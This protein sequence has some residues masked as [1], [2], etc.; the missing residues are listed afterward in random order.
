M[1]R[2][3]A[4]SSCDLQRTSLERTFSHVSNNVYWLGTGR[5]IR[6]DRTVTDLSCHP[7]GMWETDKKWAVAGTVPAKGWILLR[8]S[9]Q[10][11]IDGKTLPF[12]NYAIADRDSHALTS[13]IFLADSFGDANTI[14]VPGASAFCASVTHPGRSDWTLG[15]WNLPDANAI[16]IATDL[17]NHIVTRASASSPVVV[18]ERW[19]Y[20]WLNLLKITPEKLEGSLVNIRSGRRLASLKPHMQHGNYASQSSIRNWYFQ[21]ALSPGGD[22]LA[23]GGDGELRLFQLSEG[24]AGK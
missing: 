11:T 10:R 2:L 14:V 21:D 20:S 8:Q 1:V 16:H 19:G 15:C 17:A 18:A 12:N 6:S 5:V 23:E 24:A 4:G 9:F 7:L 13:G 22:L 3:D